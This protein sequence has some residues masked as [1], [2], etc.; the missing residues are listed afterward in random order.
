[1]ISL[2]G[3]HEILAPSERY[4]WSDDVEDPLSDDEDFIA[5]KYAHGEGR[6]VIETNREKLPGFVKALSRESYM[7]LRPFYQ[8]RSRWT[9]DKQSLLI[10]SFIMNIPVPPVFLYERDYNSYEV[11]DGQQR[12]TALRDFYEN[13]FSLRG[14]SVWPEL[15]GKKYHSLPNSIRAALDRRSISSVVV[16][17][18]STADEDDADFLREIVF[19]RLNTGGTDLSPQEIRNALY[20]SDFNK[21]LTDL[22]RW[23]MFR[24]IW[25]IP[26]Y[27][28]D[29][30][31]SNP[32]LARNPLYAKMEDIEIVLR[33]FALRHVDRYRRGMRGFLDTYMRRASKFRSEDL[34]ILWHLFRDTMSLAYE[35]YGAITF[36]P[37]NPKVGNWAAKPHKALYDSVM[38]GLSRQLERSDEILAKRTKIIE[39]TE[40][41]FFEHPEGT[42]TG[43]KNSKADVSQRIDLYERMLVEALG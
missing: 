3:G 31:E 15:N 39:G 16:L 18:E 35:L 10:E 22:S 36:K 4:M 33:F 1:M 28:E 41:L 32:K 5:E 27:A 42:F 23:D 12:I 2:L 20:Q 25:G 7:D 21:M 38:V 40:R 6:I 43:R 26:F 8:R 17:K 30:A 9:R 14:L 34:Q 29:E 19:E 13:R 11:M 24:L 37:F